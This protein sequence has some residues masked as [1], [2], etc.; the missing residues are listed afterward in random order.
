MA[1]APK[2]VRLLNEWANYAMSGFRGKH[3]FEPFEA[4]PDAK[5]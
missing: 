4:K 1:A 5:A 3:N 2:I